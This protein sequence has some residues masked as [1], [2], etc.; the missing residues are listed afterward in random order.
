MKWSKIRRSSAAI[1][2]I[3]SLS[4]ATLVACGTAGETETPAQPAAAATQ[5][6]AAPAAT[7]PPA[8]AMTPAS[9][10]QSAPTAAPQ[11]TP[12]GDARRGPPNPWGL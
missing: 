2:G 12:A 6:A 9:P 1:L 10:A 8:A 5:P 4:L 3:V 11:P 7:P